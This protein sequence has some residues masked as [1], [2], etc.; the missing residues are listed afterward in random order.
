MH[1]LVASGSPADEIAASAWQERVDMIVIATHGATR[2]R[3]L[4]YGNGVEAI[5]FGSVTSNVLRLA[6]CPVLTVHI[7]LL[8]AEA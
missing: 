1:S 6:L 4:A 2:A 5:P 3:Y 7:P 8:P